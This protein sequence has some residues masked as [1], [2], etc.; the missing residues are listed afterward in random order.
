M[1]PKDVYGWGTLYGSVILWLSCH[2]S[3][4]IVSPAFH[5]A[6]FYFF[7]FFS[8]FLV[9]SFWGLVNSAWNLCSV[10]KRQSPVNIETSHMIFDPFLTPLRFNT[11]G[12]KVS[13]HVASIVKLR[14]GEML[15]L[16]AKLLVLDLCDE[17]VLPPRSN[18][19]DF[20]SIANKYVLIMLFLATQSI[21]MFLITSLY[22]LDVSWSPIPWKPMKESQKTVFAAPKY[23]AGKFFLSET[24]LLGLLLTSTKWKSFYQK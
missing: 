9:P 5:P 6:W 12:R 20:R 22:F 15:I 4:Y 2:S 19:T 24:S 14:I 17:F 1:T 13:S 16:K 10:G 7:F 8:L 21:S 3:Y 23:H 11:G 18:I